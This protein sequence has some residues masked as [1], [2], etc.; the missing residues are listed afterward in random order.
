MPDLL[1]KPLTDPNVVALLENALA[2]ARAGRLIGVAVVGVM[3][4]NKPAPHM[5]GSG[6]MEMVVG[7]DILK[8][9]IIGQIMNPSKIVRAG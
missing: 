1:S 9:T 6:L 3:G 5:A 8:T 4:P 7:C 2:E